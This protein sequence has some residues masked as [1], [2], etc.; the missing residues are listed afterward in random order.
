MRCRSWT[1]A[2]A[3]SACRVR[4]PERPRRGGVQTTVYGL[5]LSLYRSILPWGGSAVGVR[6]PVVLI[7]ERT[8]MCSEL[9]ESRRCSS[10]VSQP[11]R[12]PRARVA[13]KP[14]ALV[15]LALGL[16]LVEGLEYDATVAERIG[17][18]EEPA[19]LV[20]LREVDAGGHAHQVSETGTVVQLA[21]ATPRSCCTAWSARRA[22]ARWRWLSTFRR[23][24]WRRNPSSDTNGA[25]CTKL[26]AFAK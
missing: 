20:A 7:A 13:E 9:V 12:V 23:A 11:G 26:D 3:S 24:D 4:A 10:T 19:K 5:L 14:I 25:F 22:I 16:E 21:A 17:A 15:R 6:D 1:Y 8:G 2:H 18:H